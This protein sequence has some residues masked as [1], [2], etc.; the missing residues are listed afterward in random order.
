[1][2]KFWLP[3]RFKERVV[4]RDSTSNILSNGKRRLLYLKKPA[5]TWFHINLMIFGDECVQRSFIPYWIWC[6]PVMEIEI[7]RSLTYTKIRD[8]WYCCVKTWAGSCWSSKR[9]L[10]KVPAYVVGGMWDLPCGR[11][12]KIWTLSVSVIGIKL[13]RQFLHQATANS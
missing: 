12:S 9:R 7:N 4:L 1:M 2:E 8:L 10:F 11:A 6:L 5:T 13:A 3:R